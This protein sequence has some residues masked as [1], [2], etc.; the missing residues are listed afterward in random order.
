MGDGCLFQCMLFCGLPPI[1][2]SNEQLISN[3][4]WCS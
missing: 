1:N 4:Q 2:N 3:V